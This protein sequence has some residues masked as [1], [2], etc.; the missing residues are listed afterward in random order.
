MFDHL[1]GNQS[2]KDVTGRFLT[3]GRVPNAL[4]FAGPEGVGKKQFAI[5]LA[6]SIIC[7][8][9]GGE[10]CNTCSACRRAQAFKFPPSDE[11]EEYKRVIFGEHPD[12]GMVIPY[13]RNILVDAIR[14]LEVKANFRPY[15]AA[16]RVFIIDNA[17][18]MNDAAANALL[19]TLEEPPAT[20]HIFLVTSKPDALLPTIRSRSQILRFGPVNHTEIERL[21]L[22]THEYSQEDAH[23]VATYSA[24]NVAAA[25]AAELAPQ[26][27]RVELALSI[28]RGAIVDGDIVSLLRKAESVSDAKNKD[29]FEPFLDL[30]EVAINLVWSARLGSEADVDSDI[31]E[32]ASQADPSRLASLV[33]EI[34]EIRQTLAVN[35][36]RKVAVDALM[37]SFAG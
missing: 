25:I 14:A 12:V 24:G 11:R 13:G 27:E 4:L 32:L 36:N 18:L 31:A 19:K 17:H 21:L 34:E 10:A 3:A 1:I 37:V 15:E 29:D 7:R 9:G 2:A 22:T 30:L 23:L 16:S 5:E 35:I 33:I 28:L 26:R 20:S 6:R 8:E